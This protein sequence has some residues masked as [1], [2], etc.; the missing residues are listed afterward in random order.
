MLVMQ[1]EDDFSTVVPP[2][3]EAEKTCLLFQIRDTN[4][5][6]SYPFNGGTPGFP[7]IG[8]RNL[9]QVHSTNLFLSGSHH[10]RLS[11][12]KKI[13][14]LLLLNDFSIKLFIIIPISLNIVKIYFYNFQKN[15][16]FNAFPTTSIKRFVTFRFNCKY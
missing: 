12:K 11:R 13:G 9:S 4:G 15:I 2:L 1:I 5:P 3:F 6:I 8:S 14:V 16:P 10:P 7:T